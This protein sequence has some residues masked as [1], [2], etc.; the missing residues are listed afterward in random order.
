[1]RRLPFVLVIVLLAAALL[2]PRP[3]R[4]HAS[5]AP[6]ELKLE[7]PE[8]E[9]SRSVGYPWHGH[10]ERG[11]ALAEDAL[12][13][14]VDEYTEWGRFYGTWQLVQLVRRAAMRVAQQFPGSR[15]SVGELSGAR[16]GRISGHHS[17][18]NGRDIDIAFYLV[19][20]ADQLATARAFVHIYRKS[21]LAYFAGGKYHFDDA[22]NWALLAKLLDDDDARVQFVFVAKSMQRRLLAQAARVSAPAELITRAKAVMLEPTEGNRHESHFH[23]RIYC[24]ASDRPG[25][26]DRPPFFPWYDGVPPGGQY[27]T[28]SRGIKLAP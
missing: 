8:N 12:I 14:H 7:P 28:I 3:E 20:D 13:R 22:R 1:M 5:A 23:V 27:A 15:L 21:G 9:R 24:P 10:L 16:G 19:D 26:Y 11:M 4:A 2:T 6:E 18:R 17:H 25:C